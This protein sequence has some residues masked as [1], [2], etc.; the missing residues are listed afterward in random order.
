MSTKPLPTEMDGIPSF[1]ITVNGRRREYLLIPRDT[2]RIGRSIEPIS[3]EVRGLA[4]AMAQIKMKASRARNGDS[5]PT[6]REQ[7]AARRAELF[8]KS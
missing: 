6:L 5:E 8:G 4:K 3:I 7:V 1:T 2:I